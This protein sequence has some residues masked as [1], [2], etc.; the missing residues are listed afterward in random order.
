MLSGKERVKDFEHHCFEHLL[1]LYYGD[2][3]WKWYNA[4]D[5]NK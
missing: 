5:I 3:I 4:L 2:D 1:E